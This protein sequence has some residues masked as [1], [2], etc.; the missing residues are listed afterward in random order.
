MLLAAVGINH[1]ENDTVTTLLA[2]PF[3]IALAVVCVNCVR[4]RMNTLELFGFNEYLGLL[5]IIGL[6]FIT[7]FLCG[8]SKQGWKEEKRSDNSQLLQ[9]YI[10]NW[11]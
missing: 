4:L 5:G 3:L 6:G 8:F 10:D 7:D 1:I 2:I 9:E 11:E